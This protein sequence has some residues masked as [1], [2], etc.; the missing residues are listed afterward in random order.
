MLK[1]KLLTLFNPKNFNKRREFLP[2]LQKN[3]ALLDFFLQP[4]AAFY[5]DFNYNLVLCRMQVILGR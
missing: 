4:S 2:R 5:L 1:F 3:G